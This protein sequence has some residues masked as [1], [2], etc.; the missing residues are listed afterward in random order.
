MKTTKN[1]MKVFERLG[2][3]NRLRRR[4]NK[5]IYYNKDCFVKLKPTEMQGIETVLLTLYQDYLTNKEG[6]EQYKGTQTKQLAAGFDGKIKTYLAQERAVRNAVWMLIPQ[7]VNIR[8]YGMG[9]KVARRYKLNQYGIE[10]VEMLMDDASKGTAPNGNEDIKE[11]T[12]CEQ[13]DTNNINEDD[14]GDTEDEL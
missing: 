7:F 5:C 12:D 6:Y 9:F 11:N 13:K 2:A 10:I 14:D 8:T 3:Y 1:G 4:V